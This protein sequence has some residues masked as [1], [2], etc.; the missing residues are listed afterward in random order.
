MALN[1]IDLTKDYLTPDVLSKVAGLAGEPLA[2]TQKA[3][4]ATVP[5]LAGIACNQASTPGGASKILGLVSSSGLGPG[6]LKNFS[7][8]LSGGSA[9]DGLLKTGANLLHGL[10]GDRVGDVAG[11]I[12]DTSGVHPSSANKILAMLAPLFFGLL[13]KQVSSGG[14]SAANL[15]SL[16]A[17]HR[18]SILQSAP[19]GLGPALG[20]SSNA[21]LCGAQPI[22][23]AAP[24][25]AR[26][27]KARFP[28]W[29][30]LVP[31]LAIVALIFGIRPCNEPHGPRLTSIALPCGTVLSV[32]EGSFTYNLANFLI[33][34]SNS[35]L[36]KSFVFDHLNFDSGTT[37][38]TSDSNPTV[39]NLISILKCYPNMQ[40]ELVGHTDNTG[41]AAAN[42]QLSINRADAIRDMAVQAGV[43]A[44][45]IST[46]GYG[47]EKPIAS[48]DTDEGR[49]RNRRTEL[50]VVSK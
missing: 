45:H 30:W 6:V 32:T 48:N 31:L 11:V 19:A 15:P 41:D 12:A 36:P 28:I 46:A 33:T 3:M 20:L 7:G 35:D 26:V 37:R 9:T 27:K 47:A 4:D 44:N 17:S 40:V 5:S 18:D 10:L 39:T 22:R 25:V 21:K 29:G 14:M 34:G 49:A 1:L 16:L 50:I 8:A 43:D 24:V 2:A 23:D 13:G 42:R 38:L